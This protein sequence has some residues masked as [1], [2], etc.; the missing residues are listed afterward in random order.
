MQ[1]NKQ[2]LL[3]F[4]TRWVFYTSVLLA[5][6]AMANWSF[7]SP[8][9]DHALVRYCFSVDV[10]L[11]VLSLALISWFAVNLRGQATITLDLYIYLLLTFLLVGA[12]NF[13]APFTMGVIAAT[14]FLYECH[15][16]CLKRW[17]S[18][19]AVK[20]ALDA[21]A[22]FLLGSFLLLQRGCIFPLVYFFVFYFILVIM[23]KIIC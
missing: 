16:L 5:G 6:L 20:Y 2:I 18:F 12:I 11:I 13:Q 23:R 19:F 8:H 4:F 1:P 21:T 3:G 22:I 14:T 10:L 7:I 15:P 17:T 9:F